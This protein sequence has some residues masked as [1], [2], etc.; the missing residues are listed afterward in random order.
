MDPL[1]KQINNSDDLGVIY[2]D[3]L[4]LSQTTDTSGDNPFG[5][6]QKSGASTSYNELMS[7]YGIYNWEIGLH[8][9][10][11]LIDSLLL[12]Q[13]FDDALTVCHTI[14]DP[15][16][17]GSFSSNTGDDSQFWKLQPFKALANT[18]AKQ[19]LE[20]KFLNVDPR[21]PD[22]DIWAWR[23]NPFAPHV[24]ARM[25]PGGL[26]EWITMKYIQILIAY[27]DY[28]FRQNSLETIPD[29]IQCY[30]LASHVYG[31][32]G[33]KIPPRGK[34]KPETYSSL[35]NRWDAFG[36]SMVQ[37]E[38]EF[39][40]SSQSSLPIGS[41]IGITGFANIYGFASSLYFCI[42]GNPQLAQLRDTIDDRLYKIRN[43]MDVTALCASFHSLIHQLI[44]AC[45]LQPLPRD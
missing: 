45:W 5:T 16:I 18:D 36:N 3:F 17:V 7:P 14:F 26:Y 41:S 44:L 32:R 28:Y 11:T 29:A 27:G 4:T 25:R 40:F 1:L 30:V 23:D 6:V 39:P 43:C 13:Q 12:A 22:P 8:A 2:G 31:P 9:S 42:P 38:V 10:M 24:V 37:L 21:T 35:L 34:K 20:N 15:S 33:Q 19:S